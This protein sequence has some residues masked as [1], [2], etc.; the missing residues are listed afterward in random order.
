VAEVALGAGRISMGAR[1][2]ILSAVAEHYWSAGRSE[3]GLQVMRNRSERRRAQTIGFSDALDAVHVFDQAN[4]LDRD[5]TLSDSAS[6]RRRW[7]GVSSGPGLS[8]SMPMIPMVP[9]PVR[10]GR[11]Q[12]F[13]PRQVSEPR[14]AARSEESERLN[15]RPADA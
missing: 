12:P 4:A 8:L 5:R 15:P 7:S 2:E 10:I 11:K 6:S 13:R 3:R 9:R 1:R 14:P